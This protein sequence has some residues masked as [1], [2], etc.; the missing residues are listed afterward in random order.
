MLTKLSES[1]LL[2]CRELRENREQRKTEFDWTKSHAEF[3]TKQDLEKLKNHIMSLLTELNATLVNTVNVLTLIQTEV[4]T[5]E[6]TI[7]NSSVSLPPEADAS[8][9]RLTSIVGAIQAVLTANPPPVAS[10]ALDSIANVAIPVNSGPQ[11]VSLSG[12]T[13]T[14]KGKTL[15]VSAISSD[16]AIVATPQ[17]NYTDPS[18]TGSLVFTPVTAVTGVVTITVTVTDGVSNA[19]RLFTVT[20][21]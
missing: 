1:I 18:P 13:T 17:V 2:L 10:P 7:G 21:A 20:I 11:T 14:G 19:I 9:S 3:A 8:L 16:A 5:L 15:S 4:Q 6:S 12:I